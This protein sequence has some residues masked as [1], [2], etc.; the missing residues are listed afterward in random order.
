MYDA[1]LIQQDIQTIKTNTFLKGFFMGAF[2]GAIFSFM[3]MMGEC[4]L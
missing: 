2:F 1:E 4:G 3:V